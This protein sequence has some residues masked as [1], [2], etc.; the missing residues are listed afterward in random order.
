MWY[1]RG[2]RGFRFTLWRYFADYN[3]HYFHGLRSSPRNVILATFD[4]GS[5]PYTVHCFS[6][7]RRRPQRTANVRD[8]GTPI[9]ELAPS[10]SMNPYLFEASCTPVLRYLLPAL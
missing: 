4:A 8:Q 6:I 1:V 2:E 9:L 10:G 3:P 5:V 7:G